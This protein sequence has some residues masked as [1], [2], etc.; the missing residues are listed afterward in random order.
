MKRTGNVKAAEV[1][2]EK[3]VRNWFKINGT[4]LE[5]TGCDA[6]FVNNMVNEIIKKENQD[7]QQDLKI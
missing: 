1:K 2:A 7:E 3:E 4:W 5:A 6:Y